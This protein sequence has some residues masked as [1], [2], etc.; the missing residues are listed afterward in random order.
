[1]LQ[2]NRLPLTPA[3][4]KEIQEWLSL[5]GARAFIRQLEFLD[6]ELTAEAGNELCQLDEN[7]SHLAEAKAKAESASRTRDLITLLQSM[8]SPDYQFATNTIEPSTTTTE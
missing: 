1:M 6:A 7:E 3:A 8:R 4:S 2:L 5:P